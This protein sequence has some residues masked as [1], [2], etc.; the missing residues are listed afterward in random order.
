MAD[1]LS[2]KL[3]EHRMAPYQLGEKM[4]IA[5]SLVNGWKEGTARPQAR[6]VRELVAILGK[7]RAFRTD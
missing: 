5:S 2:V 1:W 6:Q 7:Y 4:G 3:R